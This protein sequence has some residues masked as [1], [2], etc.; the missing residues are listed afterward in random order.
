MATSGGFE[1]PESRAFNALAGRRYRPLSHEAKIIQNNKYYK[2]SA[3]ASTK[4]LFRNPARHRT[5][6]Y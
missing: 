1:P 6:H 2:P 5:Y 3:N 4:L